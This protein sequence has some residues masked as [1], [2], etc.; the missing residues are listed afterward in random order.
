MSKLMQ[1]R[2]TVTASEYRQAF[3]DCM[4]HLL[5]VDASLSPRWFVSQFVFGLQDDICAAVRLQGPTSI[6]RAASL[7]RI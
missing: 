6:A 1:L 4:Y 7:A 2:Q 5:A 3:E